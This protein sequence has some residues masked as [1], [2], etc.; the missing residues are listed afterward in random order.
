[1]RKLLVH[2]NITMPKSVGVFNLP[3]LLT[4][5]PSPWCRKN[6]YALKKRF[7][8]KNVR[9]TLVWRYKQSLR[10]DFVERIVREI[11][12]SSNIRYV[13]IHITGDFYSKE[14]VDKWVEIAKSCP[15][16]IFRTNTKRVSF[17][18]YMKTK[19]SKNVVVR[20]STD[21][22]RKSSSILPQ[23]AI[24]GTEGSDKFFVCEDNCEKCSFYCWHHS[25][26]NVVTSQVR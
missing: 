1:M 22:S 10:K 9:E 4:C 7:V 23:A 14:Y 16:I 26:V 13:R 21:S 24:K 6:C 18:K 19:F 25:K 2:G 17:L 12:H 20:E 11:K 3:P 8:W 15:D 5:T